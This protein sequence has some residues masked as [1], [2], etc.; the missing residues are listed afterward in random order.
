VTLFPTV[1]AMQIS[2]APPPLE[3]GLFPRTRTVAAN[4]SDVE[5]GIFGKDEKNY[6]QN[7]VYICM[8]LEVLEFFLQV[9]NTFCNIRSLNNGQYTFFFLLID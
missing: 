7:F 1:D 6:V 8:Y 2:S 4:S 5:K 3:K 9:N